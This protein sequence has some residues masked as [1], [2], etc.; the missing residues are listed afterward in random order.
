M[1]LTWTA[2]ALILVSVFALLAPGYA[3]DTTAVSRPILSKD[4]SWTYRIV[5]LWTNNELR[6]VRSTVGEVRDDGYT[7]QV[8]RSDQTDAVS[9]QLTRD[10][11]TVIKGRDVADSG[12]YRFPMKIGDKWKSKSY[13]GGGYDGRG[14]TGIPFEVDYE[15]EVVGREVVK[16]PAGS[17]DTL[18]IVADG[19]L[20][21]DGVTGAKRKLT[22]WYSPDTKSYVKFEERNINTLGTTS[23]QFRWELVEY[24]LSP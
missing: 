7:L 3:Q 14:R 15:R 9:S 1:T 12:T 19:I 21:G 17:F 4:D 2:R 6:T 24:K 20:N 13:G 5:D 23:S 16:V 8:K 22:Y 11:N 10:L 18:K